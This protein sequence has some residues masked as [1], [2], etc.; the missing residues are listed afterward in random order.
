MS[1]TIFEN[2]VSTAERRS[3]VTSDKTT[4]VRLLDF[5]GII[6]AITGKVELV[7]EGEQEGASFVA[8]Q[9]LSA[10]IKTL[11]KDYF[12]EIQK[13]QH[14]DETTPYDDIL[15]WFFE[16][17]NFELLDEMN[18]ELYKNELDRIDPLKRLISKYQ[19]DVDE[20]ERYFLK[21]FVLWALVE[22]KKLNK[23]RFTKGYKFND[24]YGSYIN[25]L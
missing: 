17:N 23:N 19:P 2:L 10:S 24:L 4:V 12:P 7:Y 18:D 25:D 6:P 8:Q 14:K 5:M 21:E 9:L 16:E 1:I 3:I 22:H 11:F 20:N 13:L 15:E